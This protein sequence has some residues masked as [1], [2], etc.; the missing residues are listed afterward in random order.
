ML[1]STL[2]AHPASDTEV[3]PGNWSHGKAGARKK[4]RRWGRQGTVRNTEESDK[5]QTE[6]E[7]LQ[8]AMVSNRT[9]LLYLAPVARWTT[10]RQ[11]HGFYSKDTW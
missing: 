2:S 5:K 1:Q 3:P 9:E 10:L 4:E 8:L 6:K 11:S 7:T